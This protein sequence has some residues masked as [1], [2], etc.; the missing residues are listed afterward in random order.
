[1]RV[2]CARHWI[3]ATARNRLQPFRLLCTEPLIPDKNARIAQLRSFVREHGLDVD[4]S[5]DGRTRGV[6]ARIHRDIVTCL[7]TSSPRLKELTPREVQL[8][9]DLDNV[10]IPLYLDA[11]TAYDIMSSM[12]KTLQSQIGP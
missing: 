8:F 9:W 10:Q 5:G 1:M 6:K 12:N 4:I 2:S 7:G 11:E 3:G